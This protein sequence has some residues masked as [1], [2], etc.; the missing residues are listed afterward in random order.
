MAAI[1]VLAAALTSTRDLGLLPWPNKP[2]SPRT[3]DDNQQHNAD[4][5]QQHNADDNQQH[6]ISKEQRR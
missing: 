4:D 6:N 3:A 2:P 1:S 5:N